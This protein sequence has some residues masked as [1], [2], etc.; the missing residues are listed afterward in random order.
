EAVILE[1]NYIKKF[2]PKYN[3]DGKD[4][5]SWNYVVVS[6]DLF[7]RVY[8]VRQHELSN[9]QSQQIQQTQQY[10][11]IFGPYPGLKTR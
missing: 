7:P 2:L 10:K 6:D 5:K 3:V 11:Y 8:T 9:Q 4:D 1:A